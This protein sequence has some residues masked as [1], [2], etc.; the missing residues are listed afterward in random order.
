[1]RWPAE[2]KPPLLFKQDEHFRP[3]LTLDDLK[4][5]AP[6]L[7]AQGGDGYGREQQWHQRWGR[8]HGDHVR[9]ESRGAAAHPTGADR[10]GG[11]GSLPSGHHGVVSCAGG[12]PSADRGG[13]AI[14]DFE[15]CEINEA[16]AAQYIGCERELGLNREITN[17]NGSGIGLG[18]LWE[19]R[20]RAL[21]SP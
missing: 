12:Y 16:F 6:C 4:N 21:W 11:Q 10:G 9:T 7:S 18:I 5:A 3:G 8:R 19:Q 20:V 2:K 17:V 13:Y 15:L 1:L 14:A